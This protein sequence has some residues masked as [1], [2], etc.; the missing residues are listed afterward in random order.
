MLDSR[1]AKDSAASLLALS[2][3]GSFATAP[4]SPRWTGTAVASSYLLDMSG[5]AALGFVGK[6]A[7][8]PSIACGPECMAWIYLRNLLVSRKLLLDLLDDAPVW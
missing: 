5:P 4:I 3:V 8:R 2:G 6:S 7:R 1:G